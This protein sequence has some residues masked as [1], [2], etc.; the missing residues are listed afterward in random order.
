MKK[1]DM[2]PVCGSSH[3]QPAYS[4]PT[5]RG[6]D[7]KL[8]VVDEC[9]DCEHQFMNPQPS[10]D[11]LQPY[12]NEGYEP[13]SP[14][15]GSDTEDATQILIARRSGRFRHIP[16]PVGQRLLDVGC[17]AGFFL[18]IAKKL[19]AIEQG[20]EPSE[21][22]ASVAKQQGLNVFCGTLEDFVAQTSARF[23]VITSNHVIEHVPDPVSTLAAM[24]RLLA[25]GGFIWIAVPNA[26]Y[27]PSKALKG[28]WHS[29]DL[30]YHLMQF[31]PKSI[32]AAGAAA[33]LK[34]RLQATESIPRIVEAS[35][36][37]YFRY[38][39]LLPRKLTQETGALRF[40]AKRYA[41][42]MDARCNGEGI[43]TEFVSA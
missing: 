19:G 13:Y 27:P 18:R 36:G 41:A 16:I 23:D 30:P 39:W 3:H 25:P 4:A 11:E 37:Q 21:Y 15:H 38:R 42:L 43:I 34:V 2:C 35:L 5:T 33:G 40:L 29:A 31:S 7:R 14:S 24:K 20:V 1:L 26:A 32:A 9:A 8:W 10:W 6:Q 22:A 28:L 12:Y 17:G